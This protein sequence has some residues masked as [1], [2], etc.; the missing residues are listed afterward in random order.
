MQL[1]SSYNPTREWIARVLVSVEGP[2]IDQSIQ[3][4]LVSMSM[5]NAEIVSEETV[6]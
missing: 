1:L 5:L 6:A 2:G 3:N 4:N